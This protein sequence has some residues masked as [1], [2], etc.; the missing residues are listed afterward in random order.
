MC[1]TYFEFASNFK[2]NR[3]GNGNPSPMRENY[4]VLFI[5]HDHLVYSAPNI[6]QKHMIL[7]KGIWDWFRK[8]PTD[9]LYFVLF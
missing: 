1:I 3:I 5:S 7:F 4:L 6:R 2:Q 8:L 9:K